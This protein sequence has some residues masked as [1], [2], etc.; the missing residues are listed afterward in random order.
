MATNAVDLTTIAEVTALIS[1]EQ[2]ADAGAS[3]IIQILI[4]AMSRLVTT[5]VLG[6]RNVNGSSALT[7]VMD[8]NGSDKIVLKDWPV[9][10]IAAL[11]V[12]NVAIPASPDGVQP[13]FVFDDRSVILLPNTSIGA[14]LSYWNYTLGRFPRGRLNVSCTYTAGYGAGTNPPADANYN[15]APTDLGAA[16]TYLVAQEYK[17]RNWIDQAS[18]TLSEAH[19]QVTFTQKEWP[20]WV[21]R[22]MRNYKRY[23]Y[24]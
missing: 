22:V 2:A 5:T 10:A 1:A 17:R 21:N 11:A 8:G 6:R 3:G 15:G 14:P 19:E 18:K 16:V 13:G 4:T 12:W 7:D 24:V 20:L 9:T 23:H